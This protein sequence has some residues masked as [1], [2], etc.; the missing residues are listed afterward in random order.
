MKNFQLLLEETRGLIHEML[1]NTNNLPLPDYIS[2]KQLYF[3][4]SELDQ[5]EQIKNVQL[6]YPYYPRGIAD[7]WDYSNP[8]AVKLLELL[9]L[10]R[11]L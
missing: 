5:M 10:Y 7:S 1:K 6:F 8:L 9:E 4:L 11:K 2:E 3:I